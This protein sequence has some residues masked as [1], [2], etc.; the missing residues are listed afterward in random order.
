MKIQVHVTC[1]ELA[2]FGLVLFAVLVACSLMVRL[3]RTT[4][5]L[6]SEDWVGK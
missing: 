6:L 2:W 3:L 4:D 1:F 5:I